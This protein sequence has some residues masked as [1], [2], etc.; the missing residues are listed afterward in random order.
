MSLCLQEVCTVDSSLVHEL[1]SADLYTCRFI[2]KSRKCEY[3]TIHDPLE[4]WVQAFWRSRFTFF[5][6]AVGW[7]EPSFGYAARGSICAR[8]TRLDAKRAFPLIL[9]HCQRL[10]PMKSLRGKTRR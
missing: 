7:Y 10:I 3:D 9:L 4:F 5:I 2:P 6:N 8:S 1:P